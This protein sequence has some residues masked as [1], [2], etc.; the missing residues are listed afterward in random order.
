MA[1]LKDNPTLTDLQKHIRE[2][3]KEKG[4]DTN[5]I[6]EIYLLFSEEAGELAKAIRKTTGFKGESDENA[7]KNLRE[8]FA[9]VLNYLMDLAN[10]FDIDLEEVY[11]EK[12]QINK[13][14]VWK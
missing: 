3:C 4:W 1:D 2:V 6:T 13:E 7:M 12:H 10:Y 8:E 9:D 5:S 11:R 14:R